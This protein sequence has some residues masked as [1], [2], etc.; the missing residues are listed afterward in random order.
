MTQGRSKW[1]PKT[2]GGHVVRQDRACLSRELRKADRLGMLIT[3]LPKWS[4][5]AVIAWQAGISIEA[6]ASKNALAS[7]LLTRFGR[8]TSCW[9]MVCWVAGILG[10]LFGLHTGR[11]LRRQSALDTARLLALERRLNLVPDSQAMGAAEKSNRP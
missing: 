11:L 3:S 6:L 10:I 2:K 7:L 8:E 9:E 4:A 1:E 5:I